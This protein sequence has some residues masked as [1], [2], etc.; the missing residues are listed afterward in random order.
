MIKSSFSFTT[1]SELVKPKV[2]KEQN[3]GLMETFLA[4]NVKEG[5]YNRREFPTSKTNMS[6]I[7]STD[8][9]SVS[10]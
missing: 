3:V 10:M 9:Q 7:L 2:T 1:L 6:A 4:K 8:N 5:K